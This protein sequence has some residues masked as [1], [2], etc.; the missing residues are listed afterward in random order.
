M[1]KEITFAKGQ[2]SYFETLGLR[3]FDDFYSY[4]DR[5]Y[6]GDNTLTKKSRADTHRLAFGQT[7]DVRVF[8]LK[9]FHRPHYKRALRAW[10]AFGRPVTYGYI[11]WHNANLLRSHGIGAYEP[12]CFGRWTVCGM[13]RGSF[14]LT[15]A[16]EAM[17]L[18]TFIVQRWS[19]M[20]RE[21]QQRITIG[22]GQVARRV[23]DVNMAMR[24]MYIKHMFIDERSALTQPTFSFVDLENASPNV[25]SWRRKVRD[26]GRL[27]YSMA[28]EYF[29]DELRELMLQAYIGHGA[30]L[31]ERTLR[32]IVLRRA[33]EMARRR[34]LI[35]YIDWTK[36]LDGQI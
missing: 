33:A 32:R 35:P 12:V 5:Q 34:R 25:R 22:I 15:A 27:C 24:D 29:D 10:A 19:N 7:P 14:V 13:E 17:P 11:E 28:P 30:P 31:P 3:C 8:Y 16:L 1:K 20:T 26:L 9:R 18:E 21:Q 6:E 36:P 23:H 2:Q 4:F